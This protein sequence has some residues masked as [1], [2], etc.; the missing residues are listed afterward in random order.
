MTAPVNRAAARVVAAR[1]RDVAEARVL[2]DMLGLLDEH[3]SRRLAVAPETPGGHRPA[4]VDVVLAERPQPASTAPAALTTLPAA[5]N[6]TAPAPTRKKAAVP[7]PA[8]TVR[9]APAV[10]PTPSPTPVQAPAAEPAPVLPP[11]AAVTPPAGAI[12][13]PTW[14]LAT[15]REH[16]NQHVRRAAGQALIA[17]LQLRLAY[18][19]LA[20]VTSAEPACG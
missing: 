4:P 17:W 14:M 20:D 5:P 9:R 11:T 13:S 19:D 3:D 18:E 1:A 6:A 10:E 12:G 15:V 2:L 7:A 8:P 16:D